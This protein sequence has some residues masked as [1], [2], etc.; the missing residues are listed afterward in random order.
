MSKYKSY[1][2]RSTNKHGK[3]VATKKGPTING[4]SFNFEDS[5]TKQILDHFMQLANNDPKRA[6]ALLV[7]AMNPLTKT[8]LEYQKAAK[9]HHYFQFVLIKP[10]IEDHKMPGNVWDKFENLLKNHDWAYKFK[11]GDR[12]HFKEQ[13]AN[14]NAIENLYINLKKENSK[15]AD[16]LYNKY[17]KEI[18]DEV[19]RT[20]APERSSEENKK[21]IDVL[22]DMIEKEKAKEMPSK[23]KIETLEKRVKELK[24][25]E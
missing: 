23:I 9:V 21:S 5:S 14:V 11:D 4:P 16:E 24:S 3:F 22:I 7:R 20:E 17:H 15:K 25:K 8:S 13:S 18:K 10:N 6:D 19:I 2:D 12:N 1:L